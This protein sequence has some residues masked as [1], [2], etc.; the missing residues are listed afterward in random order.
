MSLSGRHHCSDLT[1]LCRV[2]VAE[3]SSY[4]AS[5]LPTDQCMTHIDWSPFYDD[6][7]WQHLGSTAAASN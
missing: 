1:F 7:K 6:N 3:S 5:A 2:P 4:R